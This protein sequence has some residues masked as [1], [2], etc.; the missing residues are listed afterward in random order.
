LGTA[1]VDACW[2]ELMDTNN[3]A[4]RARLRLRLMRRMAHSFCAERFGNAMT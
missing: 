1:V 2:A 4:E 3:K